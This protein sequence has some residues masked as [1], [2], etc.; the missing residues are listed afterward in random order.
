MFNQE[1]KAKWIAA[2]RSGEYQQCKGK[3]KDHEGGYCCLGVLAKIEPRLAEPDP[4]GDEL[5]SRDSWT[6]MGGS[7]R[8]DGSLSQTVLSDKN[9]QGETFAEIA[10]F[11]EGNY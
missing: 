11:I 7:T 8:Y 2:L 10:D 3:L 4:D 1:V 9:D 6:A 5:L